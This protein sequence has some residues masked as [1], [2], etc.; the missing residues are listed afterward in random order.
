MW[1]KIKEKFRDF[2]AQQLVALTMLKQGIR[3][4]KKTGKLF[5]G[6]IEMSSSKFGRGIGVDRRAVTATAEHITKDDE[7]GA[8]FSA[9]QPAADI[10]GVAK[11]FGFG[12][13]ELFADARR[14]GIMARVTALIADKGIAIRQVICDD[15][16]LVPEPRAIIVTERPVP[17][18]LLN[19]FLR[20]EGVSEVHLK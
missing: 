2:P 3:V 1:E 12:V 9:L 17:G 8:I 11:Q 6:D 10:S 19:E 14:P 18:D 20:I 13:V 16:Q 5:S 7:L 15:P 4:E